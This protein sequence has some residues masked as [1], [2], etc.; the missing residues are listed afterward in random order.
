VAL[1][2][3]VPENLQRLAFKGVVRAGDGHALREVL[4][5]GSVWRCPSNESSMS[6]IDEVRR[7]ETDRKSE[8]LCDI[9]SDLRK[10]PEPE[11]LLKIK[12]DVAAFPLPNLTTY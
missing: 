3:R 9:L 2:V 11:N 8:S 12:T 10:R 7:L 5:V 6:R 4:R 1:A